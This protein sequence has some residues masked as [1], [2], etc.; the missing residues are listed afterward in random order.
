MVAT[1]GPGKDDK[2][3]KYNLLMLWKIIHVKK[4]THTATM[5]MRI[6]MFRRFRAVSS[7]K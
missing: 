2:G 5:T 6:S 1:G 3:W 4:A 7:L